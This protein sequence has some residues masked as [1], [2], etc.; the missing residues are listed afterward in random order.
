MW[1]NLEN[2]NIGYWMGEVYNK[3]ADGSI[4]PVLLRIYTIK[5]VTNKVLNYIGMFTD[6]SQIK[7]SQ[8]N[9]NYLS[10]YD[11]LT[12]LPNRN[13]FKK[14]LIDKILTKKTFALIFL[15]LDRFKYINDSLGYGVGDSVG[16]NF[17]LQS[18]TKVSVD[19]VFGGN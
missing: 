14:E 19:G 2:K 9:I 10:N 6:L 7:R 18:A 16:G 5:S 11:F 12:A 4:Y 1:H 15:G 17:N 3:H 8:E 13:F